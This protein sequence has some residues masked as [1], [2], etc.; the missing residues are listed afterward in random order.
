MLEIASE[1][2]IPS[3]VALLNAAYRGASTLHTWTS[4][5]EYITGT[6]T[7]EEYV[8]ED[9]VKNPNLTILKWVEESTSALIGTV[10]IKRLD[11]DEWYIGSLATDPERHNSGL[12]R[13][14]LSMTE[15]WITDR[16][17]KTTQMQVIMLR[18]SLIAWYVRQ[19]YQVTGETEAFSYGDDRFG[20]PIRDD[21]EF[22][23]LKKTLMSK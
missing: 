2:D 12:G 14:L 21:L 8:R 1:G 5:A 13:K 20:T 22:I 19:G 4:E 7:T 10:T 3:I 18:E 23:V 17:G 15:G 9:L 16:G 11:N 6:R